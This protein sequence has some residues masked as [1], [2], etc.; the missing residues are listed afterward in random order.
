LSREQQRYYA[1]PRNTFGR[2]I[3]ELLNFEPILDYGSRIRKLKDNGM[4]VWDVLRSC[5]RVGAADRNIRNPA[6]NNF[7]QFF[8][9]YSRIRKVRFNGRKAEELLRRLVTK[10]I[11]LPQIEYIIL[12]STSPANTRTTVNQKITAWQNPLVE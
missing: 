7:Q 10:T 12:P 11:E 4:G 2:I 3:A 5:E 9:Q 6:A 8:G 1:A